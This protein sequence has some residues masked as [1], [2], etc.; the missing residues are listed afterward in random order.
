MAQALAS[1][2]NNTEFAGA[3]NP[4]ALL[5][6]TFYSKSVPQPF[7]TEQE[8]RPIFRDVDFVKIHTPGNALNIVDVPVS[9]GH[10]S[11][12][13]Q[14]W[15][16]YQNGKQGAEQ[17]IGTPLAQWSILT[18]AQ[19]EELRALKFFTVEQVAGAS[20]ERINQVGMCVGKAPTAFREQAQRFLQVAKDSASLEHMDEELKRRDKE[21]AELRERLA[22][23]EIPPVVTPT[24]DVAKNVPSFA[25]KKK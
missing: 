7:L 8:K 24:V 1:D 3:M 5:H 2:L 22:K 21:L 4:D 18:P 20:D 19:A 15:A 14:Q 6:V 11:R 25:D 10:K 17:V 23:L 9:E 16:R 13:P 12:F